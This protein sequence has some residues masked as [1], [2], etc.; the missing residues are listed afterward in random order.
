MANLNLDALYDGMTAQQLKDILGNTK[1]SCGASKRVYL[2][3]DYCIKLPCNDW[4]AYSGPRPTLKMFDELSKTNDSCLLSDLAQIIGEYEFYDDVSEKLRPYLCPIEKVIYLDNNL[5][6]IVAVR[7]EVVREDIN[8][9]FEDFCYRYDADPEE[10]QNMAAEMEEKYGVEADEL[11][12]NDGN[13]G[14]HPDYGVVFID[15]GLNAD[16]REL[17]DCNFP[18][19]SYESYHSY[20]NYTSRAT[21]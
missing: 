9:S 14:Y 19:Y 2:F 20:G 17:Y 11:T 5:P 16:S 7:V 12:C 1:S 13:V 10:Y 21:A 18:C 8:K 3:D 4:S 15:Y 6:V